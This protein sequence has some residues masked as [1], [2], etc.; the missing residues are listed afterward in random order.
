[1]Y[2]ITEQGRV[3]F[4]RKIDIMQ[5]QVAEIREDK[6]AAVTSVTSMDDNSEFITLEQQEQQK[7]LELQNLCNLLNECVV[8]P[9]EPR[10]C[11]RVAIGSIVF[12]CKTAKSRSKHFIYEIVGYNESDVAKYRV[13]CYAPL[14]ATLVGMEPNTSETFELDGSTLT[15]LRLFPSWKAARQWYRERKK[16]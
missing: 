7:L 5:H 10:N 14:G 1:M 15:V 8:V 11:E 9:T 12:F 6:K 16:P 3:D 2:N 4:I 13:S